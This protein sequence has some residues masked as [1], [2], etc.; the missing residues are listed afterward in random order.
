MFVNISYIP[1]KLPM[2]ALSNLKLV[3]E[4]NKCGGSWQFQRSLYRM[5][6][7]SNASIKWWH[8]WKNLYRVN[9]WVPPHSPNP[10]P[11][12]PHP[13]IKGALCFHNKAVV[14][15]V[16][17]RCPDISFRENPGQG[18]PLKRYM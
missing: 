16:R 8:K 12:T 17:T 7:I 9:M 15:R 11:S 2:T 18:S 1:E 5:R 4:T 14:V 13:L 10:N 6:I 3:K